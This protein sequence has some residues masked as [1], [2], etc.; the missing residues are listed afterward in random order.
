MLRGI[1]IVA[2]LFVSTAPAHAQTAL[3]LN[4]LGIS[5]IN[6]TRHSQGGY[7]NSLVEE[8][9][10]D[11]SDS[12]IKLQQQASLHFLP[13][14]FIPAAESEIDSLRRNQLRYA[15]AYYRNC[16]VSVVEGQV[17]ILLAMRFDTRDGLLN[18]KYYSTITIINSSKVQFQEDNA[19]MAVLPNA[20]GSALL[21]F[22]QGEKQILVG[23]EGI[24]EVPRTVGLLTLTDLEGIKA[25][26]TMQNFAVFVRGGGARSNVFII[27]TDAQFKE[28]TTNE[29]ISNLPINEPAYIFK[30]L[31]PSQN[32]RGARIVRSE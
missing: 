1:I 28:I 21:F 19:S 14:G 31:M 5:H 29:L 6:L 9:F 16:Q 13:P 15:I 4:D 32:Y 26:E 25:D 22:K 10:I 12:I 20:Q 8:P 7:I 2:M 23:M 30:V 24:F 11:P 17:D 3:D 18:V 27:N